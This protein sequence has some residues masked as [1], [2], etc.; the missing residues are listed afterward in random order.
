M[1]GFVNATTA[2]A[3]QRRKLGRL[4]FA[5]NARTFVDALDKRVNALER[6]AGKV[7]ALIHVVCG[8]AGGTGSG[9]IVDAVA[10]IRHRYP[11]P[12]NTGSWSTRSCRS[13]THLRPRPRVRADSPT[14]TPTRT[15]R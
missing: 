9:S 11:D 3:A 14:T 13:G 15:R 4:V 10:Q 12:T 2:G 6:R 7:G 1:F 5:Q 8:L